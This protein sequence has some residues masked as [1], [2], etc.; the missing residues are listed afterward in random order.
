HG[1]SAL[2]PLPPA[3]EDMC[4]ASLTR[5]PPAAPEALLAAPQIAIDRLER[6]RNAR[7]ESREGGDQALSVRLT[8]RFET[9]HGE[10][11][12]LPSGP[13]VGQAIL[14]PVFYVKLRLWR[15]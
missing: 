4:L 15:N 9:Q 3:A 7:R 5:Q 1:R 10:S 12:M 2:V 14:L 11:F 6:N 13:Q 8:C